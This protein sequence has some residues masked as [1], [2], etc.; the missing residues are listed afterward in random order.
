MEAEAGVDEKH[1]KYDSEVGIVLDGNGDD[2]SEFDEK[3]EESDELL[4]KK[5]PQ[6]CFGDDDLEMAI[7]QHG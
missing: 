3:G 6:R 7:M 1:G 4:E 2:G 5:L